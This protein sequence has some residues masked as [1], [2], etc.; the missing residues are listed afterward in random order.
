MATTIDIETDVIEKVEDKS[1]TKK[2]N[3][4]QLIVWNDNHNTFEDVIMW[5]AMYCGKT[6]EDATDLAMQVHH[7]GKATVLDG[8]FNELKPIHE[9]LQEKGLTVT[10]E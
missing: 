10:I 1:T 9:T 3:T 4:N 8:T 2:K 7:L 5:L 6:F